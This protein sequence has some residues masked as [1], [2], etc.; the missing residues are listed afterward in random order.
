MSIEQLLHN[1]CAELPDPDLNAIRKARG[2][3][4][5]ETASRTA[6]ASFYVTPIGLP[7]VVQTLSFEEILTLR[8]LSEIGEVDVVF[9]ERLYGT[10]SQSGTYTQRHKATF[11]T[12]KRNL[13]RRGLVV[14]AEVKTRTETVQL[15]R[16]RF[17]L[18]AEFVPYLPPLPTV[19]NDAPGQISDFMLRKK[20]LQL[21]GGDPAI[22]NDILRVELVQGSLHLK[23]H[24]LS[25]AVLSNWQRAA[26]TFLLSASSTK[27]SASISPVEAVLK[28]LST[29]S[30]THPKTIEAALKIYS[31]GEKNIPIE[32]LLRTGCEFGLLSRLE[33]ASIDHY[34]LAPPLSQTA[35]PYPSS[36]AWAD[37][38]TKPGAILIDLRLIPLPDLEQ[39]NALAHLALDKGRL[40]ASPSLV[41]LGRASPAQRDS[42]LAHWLA[43]HVYA[44][45][46]TL[47]Q[48]NASWGKTILHEN[49]Y[50]ARVRD[51]SLRVQLERELKDKIVVLSDHFIAFPLE[52]RPNV[53]KILRK[54]GFVVKTVR[55]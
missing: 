45:Q 24:P 53:E 28:F 31:F 30:W 51:L 26:W 39:I 35:A 17:G 34:R 16:W 11:D 25:I 47:E 14:M 1:M 52:M 40:F 44:F 22:P 21:I 55:P 4:P 3:S 29:T 38:T 20:L 6:F 50:I 43:E 8:F 42:P 41:K 2:F 46:T 12:V 19:Q 36:I 54:T 10:G 9:F 5:G 15:E 33:I 27:N 18:P 37:T 23:D 7:T 49:L 48:V 32:Q 13:V